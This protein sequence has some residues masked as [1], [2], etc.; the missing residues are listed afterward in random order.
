MIRVNLAGTSKKKL[1]KAAA[2]SAGPSKTLPILHLALMIGT[3]VG[4]YLWYSSL[5]NRTAELEQ[6][7]IAKEAE[8]KQLEAVIKENQIYEARKAALESRIKVIEGLRNNQVSPVVMLDRLAEVIDNTRFVWLSSFTQTNNS[9]TMA[10][11]ATSLDALAAFVGNM[12]VTGNFQNIEVRNFENKGNVSFNL[13]GDYAP[14]PPPKP[15]QKE[16]N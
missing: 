14:P 6:Q 1:V 16:A 9:V 15:A 5:S 13:T 3:A 10:G 4:G 12:Q 11:T 7:T 2:R 8:Q